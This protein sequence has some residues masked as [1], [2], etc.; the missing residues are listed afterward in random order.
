MNFIFRK[1]LILSA[2][3]IDN[4]LCTSKDGTNKMTVIKQKDLLEGGLL[5]L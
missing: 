4:T 1:G 5:S 3:L 2:Y